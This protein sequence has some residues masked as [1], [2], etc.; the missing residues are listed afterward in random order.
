MPI[1]LWVS[2][3]FQ[4]HKMNST[5]SNTWLTAVSLNKMLCNAKYLLL[6]D[7]SAQHQVNYI[8]T[9]PTQSSAVS[10]QTFEYVGEILPQ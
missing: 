2:C 8:N 10:F 4:K 5:F 9:N 6:T 7:H 1:I 3:S